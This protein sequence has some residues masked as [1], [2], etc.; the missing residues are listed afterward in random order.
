MSTWCSDTRGTRETCPRRDFSPVATD[1]TCRSMEPSSSLLALARER[2]DI[3]FFFLL[4]SL[5]RRSWRLNK[6][7]RKEETVRCATTSHGRSRSAPINKRRGEGWAI[8][9]DI[10][11]L[12][13]LRQRRATSPRQQ[14]RRG[15][16]WRGIETR[17]D[18]VH[19]GWSWKEE[20]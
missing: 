7:N 9:R 20:R 13:R 3:L 17:E 2:I 10:N 6:R 5:S 14:R 18:E 19:Y 11:R 15:V 16:A 12:M 4:P 8:K 1:E